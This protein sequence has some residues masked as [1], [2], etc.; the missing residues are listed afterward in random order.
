MIDDK[1][2]LGFI[3][4][5]GGSKGIPRKNLANLAGQ[6]LLAY[7]IRQ[8]LQ[9][10]EID[11][12]VVST[13]DREIADVAVS[14]GSGVIMRPAELAT[15]SAATE[16]AMLHA[17]DVLSREGDEYDYTV[18]LEP[19]SPLRNPTTVQ[20]CLRLAVDRSAPVVITVTEIKSNLGRLRNDRFTP[21]IRNAPRRRQDREP[22][23]AE[24]GVAYIVS[25]AH[26]RKSGRIFD[27]S[28]PT[29]IVVGPIEAIDINTPS[30]LLL[31]SALLAVDASHRAG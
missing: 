1:R 12:V 30:D 13:D 16:S 22:T 9:I 2:F 15:D 28:D 27:G 3:P 6:P 31:C 19:T 24:V 11:K 14:K 7:S 20:R 21:L 25:T 8:A 10:P 4:A 29:A 5:R 17:L 18:I 26:L 23:F